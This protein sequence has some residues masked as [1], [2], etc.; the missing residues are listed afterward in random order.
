VRHHGDALPRP[1][2]ALSPL[3]SEHARW[4]AEEVQPHEPSL[5]SYLRNTFPALPDV[6]DVVQYGAAKRKLEGANILQW[7]DQFFA[8]HGDWPRLDWHVRRRSRPAQSSR[9][10][11]TSQQASHE[12][13]P[14]LQS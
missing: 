5:R 6:D 1:T 11:Q 9:N 13:N 14:A 3:S 4:F 7:A 12:V 2:P 8:R 10:D